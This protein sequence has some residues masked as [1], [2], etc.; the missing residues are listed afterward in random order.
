MRLRPPRASRVRRKTRRS[1]SAGPTL[2]ILL[3]VSAFVPS[4]LVDFNPHTALKLMAAALPRAPLAQSSFALPEERREPSDGTICGTSGVAD[5]A[6]PVVDGLP[7]PALPAEA[8]RREARSLPFRVPPGA[9]TPRAP[10]A[11]LVPL[12][13]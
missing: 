10:P 6:A 3:L 7:M 13:V 11:T 8:R 2:L 9:S 12:S 4:V 1:D 5:A